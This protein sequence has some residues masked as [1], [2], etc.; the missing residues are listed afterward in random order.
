MYVLN[1]EIKQH[2]EEM[3]RLRKKKAIDH[4]TAIV[5]VEEQQQDEL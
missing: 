2:V 5:L 3:L 4:K 1:M